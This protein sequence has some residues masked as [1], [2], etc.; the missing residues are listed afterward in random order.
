MAAD[1]EIRPATAGDI[2]AVTDIYAHHV[3]FGTASFEIEA[4]DAAEMMQRFVE[5][6]E[7]GLP[8]LVAE[9]QGEICGYA[10]AALYR[11]RVAYRFT[12]EDSVYVHP[13][14]LGERIGTML[15]AALVPACQRAGSREIIAVIGD[16]NN[17]ASIRL[18]EKFDFRHAGVLTNVGFKFDRWLDTVLM[19]RSL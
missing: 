6:Q 3:R 13:A 5:V 4:P 18:H 19:Q 17:I 2:S 1:V 7:R 12:V 15:L 10:Y 8:Y 14:H 16:S 11:T 9:Q